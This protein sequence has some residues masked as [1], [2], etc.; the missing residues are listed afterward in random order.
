[1]GT[2]EKLLAL[3]RSDCLTSMDFQILLDG[4]K[5]VWTS[6]EEQFFQDLAERHP[7][8]AS[9]AGLARNRG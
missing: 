4:Q 7:L 1:M 9:V 5:R 2:Y 6:Q 8:L 3:Y